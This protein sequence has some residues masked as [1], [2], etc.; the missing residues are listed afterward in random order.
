MAKLKSREITTTIIQGPPGG[1]SLMARRTA[2]EIG[3]RSVSFDELQV[4]DL[5][6]ANG[7]R[8][9]HRRDGQYWLIHVSPMSL[10]EIRD[11]FARDGRKGEPGAGSTLKAMGT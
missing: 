9:M 6:S 4:R 10:G 5:T 3:E 11:M 1:Q 7:Y 8:L 2:Y